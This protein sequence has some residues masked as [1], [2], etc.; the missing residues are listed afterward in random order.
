[1]WPSTSRPV[2]GREQGYDLEG[3]ALLIVNEIEAA[4]LAG[5]GDRHAAVRALRGRYPDA[6]I[7]LTVGRD[8]LTYD[9]PDGDLEMPAY[10][11]EAVDE[12][13]AGDAFIGYLMAGLI[14]GEPMAT[15]LRLGSAAG[16]LAV[17]KA[18]AASSIPRREDVLALARDAG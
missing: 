7:V 11:V 16:A 6:E 14:A 12:T 10:A 3:V 5:T 13:A 1:M 15:A 9:G 2:D 8:G 4:A 18:G 17:T